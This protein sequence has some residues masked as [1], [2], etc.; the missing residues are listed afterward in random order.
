[1]LK[2]RIV[3]LALILCAALLLTACGQQQETFPNQPRQNGGASQEQTQPTAV[4]PTSVPQ[5]IDYDNGSYDPTREEGGNSE[6][7]VDNGITP[8]P[9][10][11]SQYAGAT[12]VK[13][14]P[15]DKPT[16]TV[17]PAITFSYAT[18]TAA[19]LRMA[20]DGPAGWIPQETGTD[21]FVLT[22]PNPAMDYE[23]KVVLRSVA[24]GKDYSQKELIK[25]VQNQA[26]AIRAAGNFKSFEVSSTAARFFISGN[27]VYLAYK[28][29][30]NDSAETGVAGRVIV[31]TYNKVLYVL[32]VSYPRAVAD[33][34]ADG[35]YNKVRHSM[36]PVE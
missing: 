3:C 9:I 27:G 24:V 21:T 30:L 29:T 8:A 23:A 32:D 17:V 11:Q 4:P 35:V 13:I 10:M 15:V 16:P 18:Y 25:E 20:F 2:K 12:P 5:Q 36:K 7:V 22:N 34:F 1:M 33:T 28:G 14:D 26:D 6:Q 31:N 19:N